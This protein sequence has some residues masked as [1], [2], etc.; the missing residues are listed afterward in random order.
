LTH[1]H[2][3]LGF[4][5]FGRFLDEYLCC[6]MKRSLQDNDSFL[7]IIIAGLRLLNVIAAFGYF[8]PAVIKTTK[9]ELNSV[10]HAVNA[11]QTPF[12]RYIRAD[13]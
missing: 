5:K 8:E 13:L 10:L 6:E 12:G 1:G 4:D 11:G 9:Q 3:F 7:G 2:H